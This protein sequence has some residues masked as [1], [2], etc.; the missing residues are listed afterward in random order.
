M[1]F[2]LSASES[3]W[4]LY[5]GIPF[6]V[7]PLL[8]AFLDAGNIPRKGNYDKICAQGIET[9]GVVRFVVADGDADD[10]HWTKVA[11][12]YS[13]DGHDHD[14]VAYTWG[15][16]RTGDSVT[17]RYLGSQAVL[18]NIPPVDVDPTNDF[19]LVLMV[20]SLLGFP[21]IG[22]VFVLMWTSNFIHRKRNR[23]SAHAG[24]S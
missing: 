16:V 14:G 5:I 17:V 10:D 23:T 8:L 7:I 24:Q 20:W 13:H 6:L 2:S 18:A 9:K 21:V 3:R 19:L 12:S 22:G 15:G 1:S 11:F 4:A